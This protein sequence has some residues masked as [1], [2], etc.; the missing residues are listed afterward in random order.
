MDHSYPMIKKMV[1][2]IETFAPRSQARLPRRT[3]LAE[4]KQM[5]DS[6]AFSAKATARDVLRLAATGSLATLGE[7]G[8]PFA[9]LVTVAT[10]PAGEPILLLSTLAVHTRNLARDPRAS[11]LLVAPSG[12]GGDPLAGAR[13]TLV[14]RIGRPEDD[15]MLRRRFLARHEE[16]AVYADFADFGFHRFEVSSAHL[17]AGFGRIV[18][19]SRAEI[20]TD[21]ADAADLL[22]AETGAVEHMNADHADSVALYAI[23]LLGMPAGAWRMTAVDPD[24]ADLR[25]GPLRARLAFPERVT[26]GGDLRRVLVDLTKKARELRD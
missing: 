11:L 25:A 20:L 19:L 12:E 9:S 5:T 23:R 4:G 8:S 16:A 22:A 10:T 1:Q 14:G 26:T 13:L 6:K 24:G 17:V 7:D 18:D 2:A 21:C 15:P 3:C